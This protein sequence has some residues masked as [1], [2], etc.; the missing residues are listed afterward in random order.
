MAVATERKCRKIKPTM[1]RVVF[2]LRE[3]VVPPMVL[4]QE[5]TVLEPLEDELSVLGQKAEELLGYSV[6]RKHTKGVGPLG[7]ALA[8]LK[9]PV[10]SLTEIEK[11]KDI[12]AEALRAKEQSKADR[13]TTVTATW[14]KKTLAN[15]TEPIPASAI[16]QAIR[17]K[18]EFPEAQFGVDFLTVNY[19]QVDPF[20]YVHRPKSESGD[21]ELY[22]IEVWDEPSFNSKPQQLQV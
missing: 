12:T 4:R 20:L 8:N 10:F 3:K 6:L 17:I 5:A 7:R 13:Y 22:Y 2:N 15:Y 1:N 21:S 14:A 19:K 9:I 16:R 18:E 11:Y